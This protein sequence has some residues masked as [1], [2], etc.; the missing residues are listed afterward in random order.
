MTLTKKLIELNKSNMYPFHMPGHKRRLYKTDAMKDI[1]GIDITEIDDFDNLHEA[2][3]ILKQKE[4]LAR[5]IFS[6]DETHFLINGATGGILAAICGLVTEGDCVILARNCHKSV[7]NGVMLSGATPMY[8]YPRTE[9]YFEINSGIDKR[10]IENAFLEIQEKGLN[11]HRIIVVITSPTYEGVV[12]DIEAISNICHENEALLVVDSAHGAHFGLHSAFPKSAMFLG[13]DVVITSI[14]K[15]LPAPTQTA[16]IHISKNCKSADRIRKYLKIFMSSSPSYVLMAGIDECLNILSDSAEDLFG[17]YVERLND[18]YKEAENYNNLS[19]LTKEK[20]TNNASYDYDIGKIVISD[21]SGKY[22]GKELYDILREIYK[23]QPEMAAG[24]YVLL[25]TSIADKEDAFK[26]L[27]EALFNIDRNIDDDSVPL[28]RRTL[29]GRLYDKLAGRTFKKIFVN[30]EYDL[31]IT[32]ATNYIEA[33]ESSMDYKATLWCD[34]RKWVPV[35]LSEGYISAD[36]IIPYP[37]CVPIVVP[38][39]VLT[40]E[41]VDKILY[42]MNNQLNVNGI[43]ADKEIEVIWEKSST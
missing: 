6:S 29:F 2:N 27:K 21:R 31:D 23:L 16:L 13:A 39:E 1:Y 38:G 20:L 41:I 32:K 11:Y 34:N 26:R 36:Y 8:I 25:M 42:C 5:S 14:H 18:F 33:T 37:P 7:Y 43:N 15:T 22:S 28:K 30:S 40:G 19:V 10:D 12:S 4:E 17:S 35:E 9:S 3:G 24:S